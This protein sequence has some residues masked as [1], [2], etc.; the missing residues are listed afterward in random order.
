MLVLLRRKEKSGWEIKGE[1][2][3]TGYKLRAL[4][5]QDIEFNRSAGRPFGNS[6]EFVIAPPQGF[7]KQ[8]THARVVGPSEA[9]DS[10]PP[11]PAAAAAASKKKEKE[12]GI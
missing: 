6:Q 8:E 4:S 10:P 2:M 5:E 7:R 1:C 11:P 9:T 12:S 3:E